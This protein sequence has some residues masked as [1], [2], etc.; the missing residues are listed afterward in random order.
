[1]CKEC[2]GKKNICDK[3][4]RELGWKKIKQPE[5]YNTL[6]CDWCKYLTEVTDIRNGIR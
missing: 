1:M 5:W 2:E 4:A 6:T 3:C